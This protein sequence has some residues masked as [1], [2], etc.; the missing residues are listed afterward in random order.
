MG[1]FHAAGLPSLAELQGSQFDHADAAEFP[2]ALGEGVGGVEDRRGQGD[3]ESG[4]ENVSEF[5]SE[6]GEL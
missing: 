1:V 4:R 6:D 5:E 2:A 3:G